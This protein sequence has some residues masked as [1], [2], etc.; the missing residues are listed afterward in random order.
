MDNSLDWID[1][2][3]P[4]ARA[5]LLA[6]AQGELARHKIADYRP[7]AKQREFHELG[8]TK[9]ER[10]LRAGNQNGKTFCVAA[11]AAYHLTGEYPGDWTGRRW[12][13]PT[14][15]WASG[16][17][18]ET[19]RDNPQRALIGIVGE[20]GTGAV[21]FRC[22]GDYG[23]AT[24]VADLY[25]YVKVKHV[26]GGWSL[27]RFKYYAQGPKK[28]MG[29]PVDFV[30]YDEEPPED[31]YDEGLARTIATG[32]MVALS[33]TPLQGMSEVV[34]RYLVDPTPD[35]ADVNMTIE[36][37][38]HIP[39]AERAR[40]IASFPSHEREARAKG[41]PTMGSGR[42]FPVEESLITEPAFLIPDHWPRLAGIDFGW[43]HPTAAMWGA[44]DRD[45]DT[46]H[47]YDA[48]RV[49][50]Q[51]VIVHAAAIKARG[52]WI[53]VAWPHDG[54]Q[55][56][57]G[58]G[59]ELAEQY[60][61][62]GVSML[63]EM[64]QFPESDEHTATSRVSVEAGLSE[65]LDRMLTG[66]LKVAAHLTEW[67]DEFRLYHR[68]DGKV[69]KEYDDLLSATRY[70]MMMLRYAKTKPVQSTEWK[71]RARASWRSC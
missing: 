46:L 60:K 12:D 20:F 25:D 2:L 28:W 1:Q 68:K 35:R 66:R 15:V 31:I 70:L 40:I 39:P 23:L 26:S 64:A 41:V 38:E 48:Y 10:L 34:R 62:Q 65:M 8:A 13:R 18:A 29:P 51:P 33:F 14:V 43:D 37:A 69:V 59:I 53:P 32:G 44:W 27:L 67:F 16:E 71:G 55:H 42:I 7:Y 3:P 6:E 21:P 17:T 24:G 19:T 56:D 52:A 47:L 63:H 36:D 4:E 30:W 57:K 22:L 9:R 5:A 58:A 54:L 61:E 45:T 11:E 49:R 50:E